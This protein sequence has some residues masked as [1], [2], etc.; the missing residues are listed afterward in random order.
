MEEKYLDI[1]TIKNQIKRQERTISGRAFAGLVL[2]FVAI[3]VVCTLGSLSR[4]LWSALVFVPVIGLLVCAYYIRKRRAGAIEKLDYCL[5]EDV[6]VKKEFVE[7]DINADDRY[8]LFFKK[9]GRYVEYEGSQ[10]A[11][12]SV[13]DTCYLLKLGGSKKIYWTFRK[14]DWQGLTGFEKRGEAYYPQNGQ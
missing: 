7:G 5:V 11:K 13:G 10:Y 4:F 6:C 12:I 8:F 1:E 14:Y 3:W 9:N 2:I